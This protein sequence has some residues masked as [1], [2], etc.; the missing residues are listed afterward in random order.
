MSSV[1]L[2]KEPPARPET[3]PWIKRGIAAAELV[4]VAPAAVF[5]VA[6]LLRGVRTH[7]DE[8]SF[9]AGQI[10]EWYTSRPWTTWILLAS[11]PLAAFVGGVAVLV[12]SWRKYADLRQAA[13]RTMDAIRAYAS[14]LLVGVA[15]LVAAA[16]LVIVVVH[17]MVS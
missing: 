7:A 16:V 15:T 3:H 4:L 13:T 12:H 10:M 9:T 5:M 6:L 17:A 14:T 2:P 8:P 1:Y 11:M